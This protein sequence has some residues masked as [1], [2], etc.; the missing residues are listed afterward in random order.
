M[1]QELESVTCKRTSLSSPLVASASSTQGLWVAVVSEVVWLTLHHHLGQ[2]HNVT[3]RDTPL[4]EKIFFFFS[5]IPTHWRKL[6][7]QTTSCFWVAYARNWDF[8]FLC[9]PPAPPRSSLLKHSSSGWTFDCVVSWPEQVCPSV[10][11]SFFNTYRV[12][13]RVWRRPPPGN[14]A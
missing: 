10:F 2:T 12:C 14:H 9:L 11:F 8:F 7:V 13:A 5:L 4:L 3:L 6:L 1:G